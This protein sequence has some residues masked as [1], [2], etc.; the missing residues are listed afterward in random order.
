[1][2]NLRFLAEEEKRTPVF[3]C[4][5]I[6]ALVCSFFLAENWFID[7]A[8][9]AVLLCGFPIVKGAVVGLVTEFDIKADVLVSLALVASVIIGELFAA[10]EIAV[11]MIIGGWLEER[12]VA[13]AQEGIEKL[14]RLSPT[15][16]RVVVDGEESIIPA[17][18][19]AKGDIL[20]II[21]G[22][23]IPVDGRLIAGQS[24]VDQSI[25]TGES[26]PVEKEINDEVFSG[27]VNQFGTF[28][29]VAEKVGQDSSLQKM[30]RLVESADAQKSP[31]VR[32]ADKWATWIVVLSLTTAILTWLVTKDILRAVTILV[33]FC[34]CALVL[35]TPTAIIAAIGNATKHGILIKAGDGLERFAKVDTIT[36]DKTGTIT[37]GKPEVIDYRSL[38]A[39]YSNQEILELAAAIE[40]RSEHPL[41]KAVVAKAGTA[42]L[43]SLVLEDVQVLPGKGIS[44]LCQGAR[45]AVGNKRLLE[46]EDNHWE[47]ETIHTWKEQGYSVIFIY[48][49]QE[50]IG[51]IALADVLRPDSVNTIAMLKKQAIDTLL[52]TGDDKKVAR[53]IANKVKITNV[54]AN[55]LP[56]RKLAVIRQLQE[57]GKKVAMIGDGVN[58]APSLKA[59][60]VGIAMGKIGSDIAIDAAD[61]VF[62][63]DD[64][65]ELPHLTSLAKKTMNTIR[66]NIIIA[67]TINFAAVILAILG[68]MSPIVGALVHN[69][70]S[71]VVII[72]SAL[73]LHYGKKEDGVEAAVAS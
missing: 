48:K 52:L 4:I 19:V 36:F 40:L 34:P 18:A 65:K 35:A 2:K 38:K 43:T 73:L 72:H 13:K 3:I 68:I 10:G 42:D 14:V 26:I 49:N 46:N 25:L 47:D 9:I 20:R 29:M 67:M 5:S 7:P 23:T 69:M 30:I 61:I 64:I 32:I 53:D 63:Q 39:D 11:I 44:A 62:V 70:G 21:A 28:D 54:E 37:Y 51:G 31:V 59:A 56:E 24:V 16:A 41:G 57:S 17:D 50:L 1:M 15:T 66:I 45:I 8:W 58:D 55:C 33:V 71:V 60:D 12:T 27:T 22:E 6:A